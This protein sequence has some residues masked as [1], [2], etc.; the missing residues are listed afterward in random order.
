MHQVLRERAAHRQAGKYALLEALA[1]RKVERVAGR[2]L[3]RAI[4][5]ITAA[6]ILIGSAPRDDVDR[7]SS[8]KAI[9][10]GEG[11]AIDLELLHRFNA[12][13][14]YSRTAG[15]EL[16]LSA[17]DGEVFVRP[18]LPPIEIPNYDSE[19]T[20]CCWRAARAC[21]RRAAEMSL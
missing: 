20:V 5:K 15:T 18:L 1:T 9:L 8:R 21:S 19:K 10:G 14:S 11:V 7:R 2:D 16:I 13:V 4:E 17:I 3:L 6:V 12:Q